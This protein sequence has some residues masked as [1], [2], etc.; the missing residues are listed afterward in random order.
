MEME[1]AGSL[2]WSDAVVNPLNDQ[3]EKMLELKYSHRLPVQTSDLKILY[4]CHDF[5]YPPMHGGLLDMWNRI[6]A[7]VQLGVQVDVIATVKELPPPEAQKAVEEKVHSLYLIERKS[8][9]SGLLSFKPVQVEIRTGLRHIR[10]SAQY[11]TVIMQTEFT[12]EILRNPTLNAKWTAIRVEN[13]EFAYQLG[14][15]RSTRSWKGKL[16]FLQEAL[17]VKFYSARA[18]SRVNSLWFISINE[19]TRYKQHH[20]AAET[21][22]ALFVPSGVDLQ[23]LWRPALMGNRVL[24]VGSLWISFNQE[25]ITWYIENV[26]SCLTDVYGYNL[27]VA[28]SSRGKDMGWLYKIAAHYSNI[29]VRL[30][31][32]DL[33]PLYDS[34]AVFINP[35]KN[36]SGVKLKTIEAARHGLPIVATDIGAEGTGFHAG[37]H[38]KLANDPEDF[39]AS[40]FDLLSDKAQSHAMVHRAHEFIIEHYDQKKALHRVL[41]PA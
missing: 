17:R 5:P 9:R 13:D 41:M 18:F 37:I 39:A 23:R 16:Y 3:Y 25:A 34:A 30:D 14:T 24:F 4:V 10:L 38:F 35:M 40:V 33:E 6:Q 2:K 8:L 15:A 20:S 21:K 12:A 19:L 7:L 32:P 31:V 1:M 22:K 36:G 11:D 29:E 28:G 26:H 27:L